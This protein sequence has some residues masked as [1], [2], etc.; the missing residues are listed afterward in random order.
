[1][2]ACVAEERV[3]LHARLGAHLWIAIW[4]P[5]KSLPLFA[6]KSC[7]Q[8]SARGGFAEVPALKVHVACSGHCLK[9]SILN[10][11]Q[12]H[13]EYLSPPSQTRTLHSCSGHAQLQL[14]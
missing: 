11:S 3:R 2:V 1:M 6:L 8:K 13:V 10:G 14:L 4:L 7:M 5:T 9:Q 12:R